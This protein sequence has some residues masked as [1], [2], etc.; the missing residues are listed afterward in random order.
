MT[1]Y[2]GILLFD[3]A[4][5][6]IAGWE[7]QLGYRGYIEVWKHAKTGDVLTMDVDE[8]AEPVNENGEPDPLGEPIWFIML[9]D[10]DANHITYLNYTNTFDEVDTIAKKW[11]AAHPDGIDWKK[12]VKVEIPDEWIEEMRRENQCGMNM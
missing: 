11:M 3:E 7:N 10:K 8:D 1:K 12:W 5:D 6:A 2:A 4:E 9:E